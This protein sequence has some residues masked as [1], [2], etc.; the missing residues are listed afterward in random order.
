MNRFATAA[1]AAAAL[2]ASHSV[3]AQTPAPTQTPASGSQEGWKSMLDGITISGGGG[4]TF[5]KKTG[6]LVY[7]EIVTK[8]YW[9]KTS[10]SVEGGWM[11]SVVGATR[12]D[13]A[14]AIATYL[15]QTQG[16]TATSTLKVPAGYGAVNVR[17]T[18]MTTPR[19]NVYVLGG[20]GFGV[21]SPK[22]TFTLGG[23]DVSGSVSQYGVT[24]GKDLSGSSFGGLAN[25]GVGITM[26][27]KKWVGEAS[28]RFTPI[29]TNGET[30]PV[31]R[32]NFSIG[33]KF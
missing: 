24:L 11:S 13:S 28:Y 5:T 3:L 19:Y 9:Q 32:L 18:W 21:T 1:F 15:A 25:V 23:T 26:P 4:V 30:T 12:Q 22:S 17:Y 14:Q 29:F 2:L 8:E 27:H 20:G 16:Q 7:G 6:G 33:Y 31:N 10:F